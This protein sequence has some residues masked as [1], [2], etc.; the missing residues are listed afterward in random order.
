MS[1]LQK[2][3]QALD[4]MEQALGD[5]NNQTKTPEA[6]VPT[7]LDQLTLLVSDLQSAARQQQLKTEQAI[8][9]TLQQAATTLADAQKIDMISEQIQ[10]MQQALTQQGPQN[11][12][13]YFA[14]ILQE[15]GSQIQDQLH[16][17]DQQV[18]QSMQQALSSMSQS[19]AALFDTHTY[20]KL[21]EMVKQCESNLQQLQTPSHPAVH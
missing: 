4:E 9:Q 21:S 8:Q 20:I 1:D 5:K 6:A 16:Q 7:Y 15:L 10:T 13:Q 12:T 17:T 11:N 18:A 19:Q 2:E 14:K 3:K